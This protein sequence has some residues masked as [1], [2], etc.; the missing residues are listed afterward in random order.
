MKICTKHGGA[1]DGDECPRCRA[2]REALEAEMKAQA[3]P[4]TMTLT[5]SRED[6]VLLV[7]AIFK[8]AGAEFPWGD[9]ENFVDDA[10]NAGMTT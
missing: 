6:R 10:R 1:F 2:E 9:A 3:K 8:A 4:T 7:A 5:L